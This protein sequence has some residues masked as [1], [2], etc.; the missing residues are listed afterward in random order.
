MEQL[1]F[2][3]LGGILTLAGSVIFLH[4]KSHY[5]QLK[6]DE[7]RLVEAVRLLLLQSRKNYSESL[8]EKHHIYFSESL[9][10]LAIKIKAKKYRP[11]AVKLLIYATLHN[12]KNKEDLHQL[13]RAILMTIARLTLRKW[14]DDIIK[15]LEKLERS[16]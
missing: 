16:S 2:I 1:L 4:L 8:S 13:I 5:D 15:E 3:I 6:E 12:Y 14:T 11:L 7:N 9:S 10:D